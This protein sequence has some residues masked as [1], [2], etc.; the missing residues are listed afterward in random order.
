MIIIYE[1]ILES[2]ISLLELAD[3]IKDTLTNAGFFT[4]KSILECA[5]YDISSKIVVDLYVA[6]AQII[7]E[8]AKRVSTEMTKIS[9]VPVLDTSPSDDTF[10]APVVAV[11]K[12]EVP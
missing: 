10:T 7:L 3:G 9:P 2:D 6:L 1:I 12:E 5:T 11:K 4:I 8:E